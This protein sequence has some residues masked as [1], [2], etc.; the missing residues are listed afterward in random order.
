M[1]LRVRILLVFAAILKFAARAA[2][3]QRNRAKNMLSTEGNNVLANV[4]A[5]CHLFQI[6]FI[7]STLLHAH[8]HSFGTK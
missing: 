1:K 8:R 3:T 2:K 5:F 4:Q 7:Y 6:I